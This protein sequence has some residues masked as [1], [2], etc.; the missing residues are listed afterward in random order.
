MLGKLKRFS[1]EILRRSPSNYSRRLCVSESWCGLYGAK[2]HFRTRGTTKEFLHRRT[3]RISYAPEKD[4]P[5]R[6]ALF[7]LPPKDLVNNLSS[8]SAKTSPT[9]EGRERHYLAS[10][11]DL[12]LTSMQ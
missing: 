9:K 4:A 7:L 1:P 8:L 6:S 10:F 3:N 5:I 12:N 2:E 11:Q